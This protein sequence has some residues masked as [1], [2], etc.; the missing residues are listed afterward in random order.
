MSTNQRV[1]VYFIL[2]NGLPGT[3]LEGVWGVYFTITSS[4]FSPAPHFLLITFHINHLK[5]SRDRPL[6]LSVS[7]VFYLVN[8]QRGKTSLSTT[9]GE[10][11][12]GRVM[13]TQ[14]SIVHALSSDRDKP[15]PYKT[16]F[17][18]VR[19]QGAS[20]RTL[21]RLLPLNLTSVI[22]RKLRVYLFEKYHGFVLFINLS[23][24]FCG[25]F[26]ETLDT[27]EPNQLCNKPVACTDKDV[28][29]LLLCI[30]KCTFT[31]HR[32]LMRTYI[33]HR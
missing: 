6:G 20:R 13:Y 22:T 26:P 25:G 9:L 15:C 11:V 23:S 14:P 16:T 3:P 18:V 8:C 2:H 19:K 1:C 21:L 24:D 4:W 7:G 31:Q 33:P 28:K 29:I 30:R 12:K 10:G 27:L 32:C 5:K 17:M